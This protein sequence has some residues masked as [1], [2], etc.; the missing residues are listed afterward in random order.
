MRTV[1]YSE[2]RQNLASI[3]DKVID[4]QEEIV[5]TR[6]GHEPVVI[7]PLSEY[8]SLKETDYLLRS[9]ANRKALLD[10]IADLDAGRGEIHDLIDPESVG[11][12]RHTA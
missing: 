6:S 9:P 3:L 5:V 4:D 7:I 2:T 11:D 10:S 8:T 12:E 1:N